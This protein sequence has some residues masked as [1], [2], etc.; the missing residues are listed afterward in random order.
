MGFGTNIMI[1]IFITAWALYIVNPAISPMTSMMSTFNST[2]PSAMRSVANSTSN[3]QP[4]T[5][6][7]PNAFALFGGVFTSI[8]NFFVFPFTIWN[9]AGLPFEIQILLST[10]FLLLYTL[11]VLSWF[12]GGDTP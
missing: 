4:G 3:V 10:I 8:I 11:A 6:F 5:S 12:K 1:F 9:A 7:F 2:W